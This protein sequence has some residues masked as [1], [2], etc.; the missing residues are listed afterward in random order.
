MSGLSFDDVNRLILAAAGVP[1]GG[2]L[3]P[4]LK[5]VSPSQFRR[6]YLTAGHSADSPANRKRAVSV[7]PEGGGRS[8]S[9]CTT[10]GDDGPGQD[11]NGVE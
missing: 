8:A 5:E 2:S 10:P 11:G 6:G 4:A 9:L 7:P 3:G 1:D